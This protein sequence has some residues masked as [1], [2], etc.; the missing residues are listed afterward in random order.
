MGNIYHV[1]CINTDMGLPP[2]LYMSNCNFKTEATYIYRTLGNTVLAV[3]LLGKFHNP[4]IESTAHHAKTFKSRLSSQGLKLFLRPLFST[5]NMCH[6]YSIHMNHTLGC[7]V[8][9]PGH[10]RKNEFCYDQLLIF[11]Q[12]LVAVFQDPQAIFII[13]IMT[14]PLQILKKSMR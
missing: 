4:S 9:S 2:L 1:G 3:A 14:Y 6:H 8:A 10:L 7:I 12:S 5:R 13:P 11:C